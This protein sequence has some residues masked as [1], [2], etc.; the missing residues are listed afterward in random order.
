MSTTYRIG[1]R[2]PL[3]SAQRLGTYFLVRVENV[4]YL[5][6]EAGKV[7][8]VAGAEMA[9]PAPPTPDARP[10]SPVTAAV[11]ARAV[12]TAETAGAAEPKPMAPSIS[13]RFEPGT[14]G[15]AEAETLVN[16]FMDRFLFALKKDF[17]LLVLRTQALF[18]SN[19][20]PLLKYLH[21]ESGGLPGLK[22]FLIR[23]IFANTTME[24][25][26]LDILEF[27][28]RIIALDEPGA[29]Q[30]ATGLSDEKQR[31][32]LIRFFSF[33]RELGFDEW[34]KKTFDDIVRGF[35]DADFDLLLKG[36]GIGF[37]A[38]TSFAKALKAQKDLLVS[39]KNRNYIEDYYR[40]AIRTKREMMVNNF[41]AYM[42]AIVL[43]RLIA[44]STKEQRGR[45]D[46]ERERLFCMIIA[47][48]FQSP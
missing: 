3:E 35:M 47:F 11:A 5:V 16:S 40:K 30:P 22:A 13:L 10:E 37:Y 33:I 1:D 23:E 4:S 25:R 17:P 48:D 29:G 38:N 32:Q 21:S 19:N 2:V 12:E 6:D 46:D 41:P 26:G 31:E 7:F 43:L 39:D 44:A 34:Q 28:S 24:E 18:S 20:K 15:Y 27:M 14:P 36:G 9:I 8:W 45:D 42:K